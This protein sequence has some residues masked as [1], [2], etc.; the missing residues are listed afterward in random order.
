[1]TNI[2]VI[3]DLSNAFGPSGFEEDV[4]RVIRNYSD[5]MDVRVDSMNNVYSSLKGN[6]GKR[7]TIMLDAHSDEV[8]FMVQSVMSN[9]LIKFLPLG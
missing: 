5:E 3:Q 4:V 2:K 9:G 7:V 6:T 1:M 8:G